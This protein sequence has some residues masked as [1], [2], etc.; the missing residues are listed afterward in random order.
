MVRKSVRILKELD[1]EPT[2]PGET[3]EIF[4]LKGKQG[5]SY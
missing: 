4:K 2:S 3:R 5:T 1:M